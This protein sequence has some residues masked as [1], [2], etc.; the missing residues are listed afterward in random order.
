MY[1][2]FTEYWKDKEELFKELGVSKV[3]AHLIWSDAV[4]T[5]SEV[6]INKVIRNQ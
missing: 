5:L 6:Y 2:N 4:D 3:A 1:K